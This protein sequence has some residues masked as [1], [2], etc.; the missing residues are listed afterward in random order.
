VAPLQ[1][2]LRIRFADADAKAK[3]PEWKTH[4]KKWLNGFAIDS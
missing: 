2:F 3:I 4:P 1:I